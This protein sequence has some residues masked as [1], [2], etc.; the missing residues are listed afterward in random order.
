MGR[1][2]PQRSWRTVDS[3]ISNSASASLVVTNVIAPAAM[4]GSVVVVTHARRAQRATSVRQHLCLLYG[5]SF[6]SPALT[7]FFRVI[8]ILAARFS[9]GAKIKRKDTASANWPGRSGV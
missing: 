9:K 8:K 7:F 3:W 2:R 6:G 4:T 5:V 1:E